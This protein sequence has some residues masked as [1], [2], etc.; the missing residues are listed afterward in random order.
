M[1]LIWI[2]FLTI[3]SSKFTLV[4]FAGY[5]LFF[6]YFVFISFFYANLKPISNL[7]KNTFSQKQ[8]L[9]IGTFTFLVVILLVP[10]FLYP[11][12]NLGFKSGGGSDA[13][14]GVATAI[15]ALIDLKYPY[16]TKSYLGNPVGP[17][18]GALIL[19]AP[20]ALIGSMALQNIFWLIILFVFLKKLFGDWRYSLLFIWTLMF[21]SPVSLHEIIASGYKL[22]HT[23]IVAVFLIILIN[24]LAQNTSHLNKY[25]YTIFLGISLSSRGDLILILP[26]LF[27]YL[28]Q[29]IGLKNSIK[30]LLCILISFTSVTLPFY[31]YDPNNFT[32]LQVQL[33]K[34]LFLDPSLNTI[35][36]ITIVFVCI[37]ISLQKMKNNKIRFFEGISVLL[38]AAPLLATITFYTEFGKLDFSYLAY[39]F[40][41]YVFGLLA[42]FLRVIE[43]I[44]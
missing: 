42:Y 29:N 2:V 28:I 35:K 34:I 8:A 20:F 33:G 18:P 37:L 3:I 10:Y 23:L 11:I 31:L 5:P 6:I 26:A 19:S 7:I 15:K 32:P 12:A 21:I 38:L 39:S 22:S 44:K 13:D 27:S 14:D 1:N 25:L 17:L 24:N 40:S 30:Y 41:S 43:K 4:K 16:Y 36:I 9:V